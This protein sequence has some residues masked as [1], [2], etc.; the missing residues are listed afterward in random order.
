MLRYR[1]VVRPHH[2]QTSCR[3]PKPIHSRACSCLWVRARNYACHC[4]HFG[5]HLNRL[6]YTQHYADYVSHSFAHS[7]RT[8]LD[9]AVLDSAVL[10][11]AVLDS[12]V[13]DSSVLDSAVLDSAVLDSAVLDSAL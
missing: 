4:L 2:R 11:S 13:L 5:I 1:W 9:S 10:D 12:S 3:C 7:I 6:E 8:V